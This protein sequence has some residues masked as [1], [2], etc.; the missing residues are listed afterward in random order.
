MGVFVEQEAPA[1]GKQSKHKKR[2]TGFEARRRAK[3]IST[4]SVSLI[5]IFSVLVSFLYGDAIL[6]VSLEAVAMPL[7]TPVS[8]PQPTVAP[9]ASPV[10]AMGSSA[11]LSAELSEEE[12]VWLPKGGRRYHANPGCSGMQNALASVVGE[13]VARGYLPC[14]QCKAPSPAVVQAAASEAASVWLPKNGKRY[15]ATPTCSGMN[16]TREV[17][18]LEAVQAGFTPCPQCKPSEP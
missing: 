13:A 2:R 9:T 6:D 15:H 5:L 3:L 10:A 11:E 14:Q 4:V 12:T 18:A 8:T 16:S 1:R 7:A 17:S